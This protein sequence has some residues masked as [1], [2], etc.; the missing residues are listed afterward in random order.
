MATPR[1]APAHLKPKTKSPRDQLI[2][3]LWAQADVR[4]DI[5]PE[6]TRIEG[7]CSAVDEATDR[8]TEEYIR[9]Q[10]NRGNMYAWCWARVRVT[11][12]NLQATDSLGCC[13][14]DNEAALRADCYPD[15]LHTAICDLADQI[16]ASAEGNAAVNLLSRKG[17]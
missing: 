16:L 1:S 3:A 5:E 2:N 12:Q 15:M 11:Y 8:D 17:R 4:L 9:S 14:Y 7:N 6:C 13:S 10:L